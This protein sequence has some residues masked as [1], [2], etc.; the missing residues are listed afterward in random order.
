MKKSSLYDQLLI[1]F[2]GIGVLSACGSSQA[3]VNATE[4]PET[5][6]SNAPM[7]EPMPPSASAGALDTPEAPTT[8]APSTSAAPSASGSAAAAS[9]K[10]PS[11]KE[12]PKANH[13]QKVSD[14]KRKKACEASCGEGTC[15]S[16]CPK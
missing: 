1:T 3:P 10:L 8:S 6:G 13:T 11:S 12:M 7:S 14:S 5:P 9:G 4:V 2:A 16:P 15:G